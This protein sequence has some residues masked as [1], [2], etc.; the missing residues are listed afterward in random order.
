MRIVEKKD[1]MITISYGSRAGRGAV[2]AE[3]APQNA[4]GRGKRRRNFTRCSNGRKVRPEGSYLHPDRGLFMRPDEIPRR[5]RKG[6]IAARFIR[7]DERRSLTPSN[8]GGGLLRRVLRGGKLQFGEA[9]VKTAAGHQFVMGA[10]IDDAPF[11]HDDNAVG[12]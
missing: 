6:D 1:T 11:I 7:R 5:S 8:G 2:I 4:P 9:R 10:L 3:T 12:F